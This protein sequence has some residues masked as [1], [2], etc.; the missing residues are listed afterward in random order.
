MFDSAEMRESLR[1]LW[2]D[3]INWQEKQALEIEAVR[4]LTVAKLEAEAE[5]SARNT[6]PP[7]TTLPPTVAPTTPD[8]D[9]ADLPEELSIAN[10]AFRAVT[11]GYGN[12]DDTFRNRLIE[13]LKLTY[14]KF[15]QSE[16]ERIATVANPDKARGRK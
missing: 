11:N 1:Q 8:I 14:P 4:G 7:S 5:F 2:V 9:P 6:A 16:I 15:L 13:Y 3:R 10:I 12:P